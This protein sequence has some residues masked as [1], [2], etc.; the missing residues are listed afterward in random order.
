MELVQRQFMNH[1][2]S[3]LRV[4][5]LLAKRS[6]CHAGWRRHR[7]IPA[8]HK[9]YFICDGEGWLQVGGTELRP[10]PGELVFI[11]GG[12]EQSYSVTNGPPYTKYWCHF[13]ANVHF[14]HL[15]HL[16]GLP[17][18]IDAGHSSELYGRFQELVEQRVSGNPAA[19]LRIQS[20]LLSIIAY[21]LERAVRTPG[22][23]AACASPE[24]LA[25]LDFI[26]AHLSDELTIEELSRHAHFHPNYF[27]RMFKRHLGMTPMRYIRER[28]LEHAQELL[29]A[30]E[31]PVR[32]VAYQSGFRDVSHF[33]AAFKKKSGVS[34]SEYRIACLPDPG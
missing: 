22:A 27:I 21:F 19:P 1:Q 32:E 23:D 29:G 25:T 11:P 20:A 8:Y 10:K 5:L 33:S 28:R 16:Y 34:P 7:F 9:L 3:R 30:T 26:D 24:L 14:E 15:F 13:R 17:Y 31:L 6:V 2:L 18:T 4:Q 12:L